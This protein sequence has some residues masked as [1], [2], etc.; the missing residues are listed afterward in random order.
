MCVD[1]GKRR[2]RRIELTKSNNHTKPHRGWQARAPFLAV[3]AHLRILLRAGFQ[4]NQRNLMRFLI[5][6]RW[7]VRGL[8]TLSTRAAERRQPM[9]NRSSA[10]QSPN[11]AGEKRL[12]DLGMRCTV[13]GPVA[14]PSECTWAAAPRRTA[15][16]ACQSHIIG[17]WRGGVTGPPRW[18]E[19]G[20]PL[21]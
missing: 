19:P 9:L 7:F 4:Q 12:T 10:V 14:G 21:D 13:A 20:E 1:K 18:G 17:A 6:L 5:D 8:G 15:A 2:G 11:R 3:R 16:T